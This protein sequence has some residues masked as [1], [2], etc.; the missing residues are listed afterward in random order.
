M[1][2]HFNI[3]SQETVLVTNN[4]MEKFY[5]IKAEIGSNVRC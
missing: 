1:N 4:P 2:T 3:L 5:E